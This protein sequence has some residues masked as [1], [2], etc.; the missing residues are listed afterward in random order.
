MTSGKA[1]TSKSSSGKT[2]KFQLWKKPIKASSE[3]FKKTASSHL[4]AVFSYTE[5]HQIGIE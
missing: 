1:S 5:Y 2:Q 3:E 4:P